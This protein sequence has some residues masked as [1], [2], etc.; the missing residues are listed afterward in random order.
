MIAIA[1][2]Y[3]SIH[4]QSY[5]DSTPVS[6]FTVLSVAGEPMWY[7]SSKILRLRNDEVLKLEE[8]FYRVVNETI[9]GILSLKSGRA[10]SRRCG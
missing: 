3:V 1:R 7:S 9:V 2:G 8:I 5:F 6:R 10:L 4:L